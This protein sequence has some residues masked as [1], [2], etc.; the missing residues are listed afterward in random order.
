MIH[1]LKKFYPLR[2][3]ALGFEQCWS[4]ICLPGL[5]NLGLLNSLLCTTMGMVLSF[6]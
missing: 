5:G 1:V 4:Y 6:R 2:V 3:G